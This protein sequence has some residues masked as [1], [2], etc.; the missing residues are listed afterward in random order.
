MRV[1]KFCLKPGEQVVQLPSSHTGR[2]TIGWQG[3][4]AVM[5]VPVNPT[6]GQMDGPW[7][8]WAKVYMAVTGEELPEGWEKAEF[9][10]TTHNAGC[11]LVVHAFAI[12][13]DRTP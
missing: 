7:G 3:D 12:I 9:I 2:P 5:W 6:Q 1:L 13:L 8:D 10:G 4:G 11:S